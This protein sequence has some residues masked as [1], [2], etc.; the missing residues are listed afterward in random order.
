MRLSCFEK[1]LGEKASCVNDLAH[2]FARLDPMRFNPAKLNQKSSVQRI[3]IFYELLLIH[4]VLA[5]HRFLAQAWTG[6]L[7]NGRISEPAFD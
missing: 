6:D 2:C 1:G 3:F 5:Y 7:A 4:P